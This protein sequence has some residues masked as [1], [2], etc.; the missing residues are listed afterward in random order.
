ML[1][2][3]F[4]LPKQH[5]YAVQPHLSFLT[6]LVQLRADARTA[7]FCHALGYHLWQPGFYVETGTALA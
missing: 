3:I 1:P 7:A 4:F 2:I 6:D 5:T